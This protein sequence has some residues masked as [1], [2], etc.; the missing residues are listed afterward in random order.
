MPKSTMNNGTNFSRGTDKPTN[1]QMKNS[2]EEPE[3]RVLTTV[4]S[5]STDRA[6]NPQGQTLPVVEE[7]GESSSLGGKSGRSRERDDQSVAPT[8]G[9]EER[10]PVTPMKDFSPNK[11]GIRMVARSSLDKELPP[12]PLVESPLAMRSGEGIMP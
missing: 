4:R 7:L 2:L 6:G 11:S 3:P 10:R 12:I 5:P 1:E 8:N 9:T